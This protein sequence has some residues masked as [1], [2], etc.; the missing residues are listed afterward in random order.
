MPAAI[1][2]ITTF[3]GG[4]AAGGLTA[5]FAA[6]GTLATSGVAG[7][8]SVA[9]GVLSGI[10]ALTGKKDL[11]KIGGLMALGGGLMS[12]LGGASSAAAGAVEEAG[13]LGSGGGASAATTELG[14]LGDI[15]RGID[16]TGGLETA[17][18]AYSPASVL[19][20]TNPYGIDPMMES[21]ATKAGPTDWLNKVGSHVKQNKELYSLGGGMLNSMFGPEA[22]ALDY[23]R[24][25]DERRR[26]NMNSPVRLGMLQRAGG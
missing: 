1:P 8:L 26:R 14:K 12:A 19:S 18:D 17:V 16:A 2:L 24:E 4:A 22:E 5:G 13:A 6:V 15:G 10:G 23:R 9:G 20:G 25:Q 11:M 21:A 3:I 7:F